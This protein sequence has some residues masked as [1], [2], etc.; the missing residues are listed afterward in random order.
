MKTKWL[1]L[2]QERAKDNERFPETLPCLLRFIRN[3][4]VHRSDTHKH[5]HTHTSTHTH[6]RTHTHTHTQTE[7]TVLDT[8]MVML[9]SFIFN[10]RPPLALKELNY[11][12]GQTQGIKL[13]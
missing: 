4:L 7:R 2:V 12:D 8:N 1:D 9:Y 3:R 11:S 10:E 13:C 5:T 6:T